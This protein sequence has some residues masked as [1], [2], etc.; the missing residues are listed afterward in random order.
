MNTSDYLSQLQALTKQN[1]EILKALNDSFFTK[2][3]HITAAVGDNVFVIPSFLSLE[4]K[5]NA[6]QDNFINL[7]NAPQTGE[8]YFN[9]DGHSQAIELKGFNCAP[10]HLT[11]PP[12][13][14]FGVETN[15]V[16]KD[17]LTPVPYLNF[18]VVSIPDDITTVNVRKVIPHNT[19]LRDRLVDVLGDK[20]SVTYSWADLYKILYIYKEDKDYTMYDTQMTLPVRQPVGSAQYVIKSIVSDKIDDNL[21]EY[22]TLELRN[23]FDG[24]ENSDVYSKTLTYKLFDQ[25]IEKNLIAGDVLVTYNNGTKLEITE[26]RPVTNSIVVRVLNGEYLNLVG[27]DSD[28]IQDLS[29]LKFFS[30]KDYSE[31]KYV[32]VP[33]EEDDI[34]FIAIAPINTRL[35]IQSPWGGGILVCTDKLHKDNA[36]GEGFRTYY[37]EN[38]RNIGDVLA[39]ITSSMSSTITSF[40][41]S[42]FKAITSATP[43]ISTDESHLAVTQINSH[44]N[45][46]E[47]IKNIRSLYTQKK[48]YVT[49][50][51]S[52]QTEMDRINEELSS[53]SFDDTSG[54]RAALSASLQADS[55][56]KNDLTTSIQKIM[57]EISRAANNSDVPIENAK[58]RI[59]G[60]YDTAELD[61][62]IGIQGVR[63]HV[64]SIEV[65][66]RYKNSNKGTGTAV[67]MGTETD[68][69]I[70]SDWNVMNSISLK[71]VPSLAD[72]DRYK[73]RREDEN[74]SY[75]EPSF[76]Q[77]DIP[78]SQGETVDI[79][80][81]VVFDYGAPFITT[82]SAW[83]K[84]VNIEFPDEYTKDVQILDIIEE[85]NND[86]ESN[87]FR[88][89][90]SDDGVTSHINDEITDQ[91]KI[92]RHNPENIS[93]G[94]YTNERRI[95]PLKDKLLEFSNKIQELEDEISGSSSN[96]ISVS[97]SIGDSET[98]LEQ[99]AVN[100]I[101]LAS[102]GELTSDSSFITDGVYEKS[103]NDKVSAVMKLTLKNTSNHVVK[104]FPIFPGPRTSF[105]NGYPYKK[106]E[107]YANGG[108]EGVYSF[109][110]NYD[111]PEEE[112]DAR[113]QLL[114]QFIT[115]RLN[116]P[117][118]GE[119]YYTAPDDPSI[120]EGSSIYNVNNKLAWDK[121]HYM[122]DQGAVLDIGA[123]MYP[124]KNNEFSLCVESDSS[125][126][127]FKLNPDE[128]VVIPI[129]FE[130]RFNLENDNANEEI[131]KI[132]AFDLRTSLYSDPVT[133]IFKANVKE[134]PT[135]QDKLIRNV[136]KRNPY[137]KYN[138][139]V[140]A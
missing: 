26:V 86:I 82:R 44:L 88:K 55:V 118:T 6:L 117:W 121:N 60:Y 59:R 128:S 105:I 13:E 100:N 9:F 8:A 137:I 74:G 43:T 129:M 52:I 25:T 16:F 36:S 83:S 130:Y 53:I 11:L 122:L 98:V 19:E 27:S 124:I 24:V 61:K 92:Y 3:E 97:I 76:N 63:D 28:N 85:N 1:L 126:E 112:T 57:D 107:D 7:V 134:N 111:V 73:F 34:V 58:Y 2:N 42:D 99:N 5:I 68:P 84:I 38:V 78:I 33:L 113:L 72:D 12:K 93:S 120:P 69:F 77:I 91:D 46:S 127:F 39:E 37:N 22:I 108:D 95:I 29:I 87:R 64:T 81:R 104:L 20:T 138:V 70:F 14:F 75:N 125:T 32:R 48:Q 79:K 119:K 45:D 4:N 50:L 18:D 30:E 140:K 109:I 136:K 139:T 133:Y 106:W 54:Q 96:A 41:V 80:L 123:A 10:S 103:S 101:S 15:D 131:S 65:W 66:Y 135:P 132:M 56:R 71:R 94:F 110:P 102:F 90:L 31:L 23:N 35:R 116:N 114:N 62:L 49:E 115:F 47:T 67:S 89:I 51:A 40:S 17:F 21:D